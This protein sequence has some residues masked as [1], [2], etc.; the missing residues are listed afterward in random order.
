MTLRGALGALLIAGVVTAVNPVPASAAAPAAP[1]ECADASGVTVVVDFTDLGGDVVV[2][3]VVGPLPAGMTGL[4]ALRGAGLTVEGTAR[5]GDAFVCRVQGRPAAAESLAFDGEDDYHE[6]C[7]DTPPAQAYWGYW[8][9]ADGGPWT[10]SSESAASRQV[11]EGGFEGWSYSLDETSGKRLP[12]YT[13][14]RPDAQPSPTPTPT[15]TATPSPRAESDGDGGGGGGGDG[16]GPTADGGANATPKPTPPPT[17]APPTPTDKPSARPTTTTGKRDHRADASRPERSDAVRSRPPSPSPDDPSGAV[18]T[19]DLP[20]P[21]RT[22]QGVP[23]SLLAGLGLL[24]GMVATGIG[25]ARRR[26]T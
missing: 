7:Q 23:S 1:G 6:R 10:Y 4:E 20:A 26:R 9:A 16:G 25:L 12:G 17:A 2:R 5:W 24:L 14:D 3:C 21:P 11:A 8:Y 15:R 18:V 22:E 13:P 19:G